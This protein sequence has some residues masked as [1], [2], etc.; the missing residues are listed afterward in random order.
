MSP[1]GH[2]CKPLQSLTQLTIRNPVP[3][4]ATRRKLRLSGDPRL[5]L[6]VPM[7]LHIQVCLIPTQRSLGPSGHLRALMAL[8]IWP[9]RIVGIRAFPI[10]PQRS[11]GLVRLSDDPHALL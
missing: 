9:R 10:L 3:P 6:W 4:T 11:L 8:R 1:S 5:V 7:Y 2:L